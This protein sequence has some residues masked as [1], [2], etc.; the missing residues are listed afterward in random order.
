MKGV[1]FLYLLPFA[2]GFFFSEDVFF[3]VYFP[4]KYGHSDPDVHA[5]SSNYCLERFLDS[6]FI[7]F[8]GL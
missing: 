7:K 1:H 3:Q 2:I 6:L 5:S 8:N 4:F